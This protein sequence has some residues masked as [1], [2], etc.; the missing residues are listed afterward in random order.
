R[1]AL[2]KPLVVALAL[3]FGGTIGTSLVAIVAGLIRPGDFWRAYPL[4]AYLALYAVLIFLMGALWSRLG[5]GLDRQRMRSASWLLILLIDGPLW[6]VVPLAAVAVLPMLIEL[7]HGRLRPALAL[8]AFAAIGLS[9]DAMAMPR[10]SAER[11][12]GMSIDYF[13][14]ST[15]QSASWGVATK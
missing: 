7:D 2:G 8:T 11:P 4:V 1:K 13:R 10:A 12:L 3:V 5:S 14:D 6:A 9:A 15:A